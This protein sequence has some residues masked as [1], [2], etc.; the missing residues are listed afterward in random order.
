[1]CIAAGQA[2]SG[3]GVQWKQQGFELGQ[4]AGDEYD[5]L[6]D[7]TLLKFDQV[8]DGLAV[9]WVTAQTVNGLSRI[10][11]DATG[12]DVAHG[13]AD[14]PVHDGEEC[15]P[16]NMQIPLSGRPVRPSSRAVP[17]GARNPITFSQPLAGFRLA[18]E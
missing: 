9:E 15:K 10:G 11:D 3:G 12:F 13:L 14:V 7:L 16:K 6:F 17:S 2:F 18:P 4:V 5:A 1:V 8:Q